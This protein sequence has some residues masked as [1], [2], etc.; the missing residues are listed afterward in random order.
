MICVNNHECLLDLEDPRSVL[1][2]P[3][4]SIFEPEELRELRGDI[5]NVVFSNANVLAEDIVNVFDEARRL[6]HANGFERCC[7][8][9]LLSSTLF[10]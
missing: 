7:S 6:V 4:E 9:H 5:P 10:I 1:H 2:R 3:T 8:I